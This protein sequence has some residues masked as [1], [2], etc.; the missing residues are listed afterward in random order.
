M[1]FKNDGLKMGAEMTTKSIQKMDTTADAA[2]SRAAAQQ[3]H[4]NECRALLTMKA[5]T[6]PTTCK[7]TNKIVTLLSS[8]MAKGR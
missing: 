7:E 6:Q 1:F 2:T 3:C 8:L 4:Y 5:L